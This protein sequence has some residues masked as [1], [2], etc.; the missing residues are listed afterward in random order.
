MRTIETTAHVS[1]GGIMSLHFPHD[2]RP[3]EYR[4]VLVVDEQPVSNGKQRRP[5]NFPVAHYGPWPST[6]SLRRE[7][8]YGNDGR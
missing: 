6:L 7:D 5:L 1:P 8:M 4:M 3:G 2:I